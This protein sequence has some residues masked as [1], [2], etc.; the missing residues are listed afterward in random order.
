MGMVMNPYPGRADAILGQD[1][2]VA[3]LPAHHDQANR[4]KARGIMLEELALQP[5]IL[6]TG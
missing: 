1:A 5:F 2:W 3:V 6:A 4:T